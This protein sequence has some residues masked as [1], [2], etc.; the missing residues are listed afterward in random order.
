[1]LDDGARARTDVGRVEDL[2]QVL[3]RSSRAP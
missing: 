3:D 1:M 2:A